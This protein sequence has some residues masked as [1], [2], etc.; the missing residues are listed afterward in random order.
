MMKVQE[1]LDRQSDKLLQE[2]N[3]DLEEAT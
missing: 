1:A 2:K 3:S